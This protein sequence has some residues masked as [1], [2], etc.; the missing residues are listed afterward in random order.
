MLSGTAHST[1]QQKESSDEEQK[2]MNELFNKK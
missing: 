1:E 2:R